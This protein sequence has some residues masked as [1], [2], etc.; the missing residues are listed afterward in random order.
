[1]TRREGSERNQREREGNQRGRERGE[2]DRER[3]ESERGL[4]ERNRRE[5]SGRAIGEMIGRDD[6][7]R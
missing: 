3:E 6:W 5:H 7:E 1:M 2:S 4:E